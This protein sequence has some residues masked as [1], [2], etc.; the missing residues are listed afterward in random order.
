MGGLDCFVILFSQ[1]VFG[2]GQK[3]GVVIS[4]NVFL[5]VVRVFFQDFRGEVGGLSFDKF[6]Y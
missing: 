4:G 5:G 3:L 6:S 2:M 1:V